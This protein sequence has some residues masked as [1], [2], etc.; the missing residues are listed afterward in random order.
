VQSRRAA[1]A[2]VRTEREVH[3]LFT[4]MAERYRERPGGYTRVMRNGFR[5]K[6]K[7]PM[8]WIE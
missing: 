1:S 7:V 4:V 6:D 8:A 5:V 2:I 3:K